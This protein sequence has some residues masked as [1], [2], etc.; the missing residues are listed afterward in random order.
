MHYRPL[1]PSM[2]LTLPAPEQDQSI[3][4]VLITGLE[5]TVVDDDIDAVFSR[6]TVDSSAFEPEPVIRD[7]AFPSTIGT[8]TPEASLVVL[9]GQYRG[10]QD[11]TTG[12]QILYTRVAGK[13]FYPPAPPA[14]AGGLGIQSADAERPFFRRVEG[15][16]NATSVRFEVEVAPA[17]Y[18]L[19]LY[20]V[21]AAPGATS[22]WKS[23]EL[24]QDAGGIWTGTATPETEVGEFFVQAV[25][26]DGLVGAARGKGFDF[27][28]RDGDVTRP[29]IDITVPTSGQEFEVGEVVS[30]EYTCSDEDGGSGIAVCTAWDPVGQVAVSDQLDTSGGPRSFSVRAVDH[31]GNET[32]ATVTYG[33]GYAFDGFFEPVRNPPIINE[34][35]AGRTIPVKFRLHDADGPISDTAAVTHIV[36]RKSSVCT[37]TATAEPIADDTTA[38][39]TAG[40]RYDAREDQFV[41]TWQTDRKAKG[42]FELE[43]ATADGAK[44][45]AWFKLT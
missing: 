18:V 14:A 8:V 30:A 27:L 7:L 25:S 9:P 40:L 31:A 44:H 36:V 26:A 1:Q 16:R 39:S 5:S 37:K 12:Q 35:K 19:V 13:V 10:E 29:T 4:D 32:I 33:A 3:G 15:V 42:C 11:P 2:S 6:P 21:P 24:T 17:E 28:P 23:L 20:H 41:F 22:V 38:S 43:V 45:V 34:M